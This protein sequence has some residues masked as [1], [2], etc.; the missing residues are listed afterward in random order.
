MQNNKIY[1][2]N[3]ISIHSGRKI[4]SCLFIAGI[5][6]LSTCSEPTTDKSSI[7]DDLSLLQATTENIESVHYFK[8]SGKDKEAPILEKT[9]TKTSLDSLELPIISSELVEGLQNQLDLLRLRKQKNVQQIGNLEITLDQLE[10]T[11][12]ELIA[13]QHTKPIGLP[14]T[15][16]AY[17]IKGKDKRG[18]VYFTGYFTPI[19]KVD[20]QPS[21]KYPY[22]IYTRPKD[23]EGDY[24]T[25]ADIE[26][27]GALD[28]QGLELAYSNNKIDIYFMQ[29]QGSGYV[30]YPNGKQSL[31]SY[32]GTNR[33]PYSSIGRYLISREDIPAKNISMKG[34]RSFFDERPDL[35]DEV[36]YTNES[37]TF[38]TEKYDRPKGA[39]HVPLIDD[40]SI[41]VD[42][43]YI[44]LGSCL[45]AKVP[46]ISPDGKT[47]KHEYRFLLAQDIG[48][49]IKGT[50]HVDLYNGIGVEAQS[51]ASA[52]HHYGK[53]WL[54]LPKPDVSITSLN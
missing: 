13:W 27:G 46:V 31:F 15:L 19:I 34:I 24:P 43:R 28:N 21:S 3:R 36:L 2:Q 18:N 39:G 33:H 37:Y 10:E 47:R 12:V 6:F 41:A 29:V 45:L 14:Q 17:Q 49:A 11:I 42:R 8:G 50:G 54:L 48:G 4:H 1:N 7:T 16:D 5:L 32:D 30:E 20:D 40:F 9:Y 44:P 26:F 52:T 35:V 51:K 53:M 23:W 38:F 25:R 22:P